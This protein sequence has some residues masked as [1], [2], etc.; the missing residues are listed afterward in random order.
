MLKVADLMTVE[1]ETVTPETSLLEVLERMK[2]TIC[3]QMP[4]LDED[5]QLVG[6]VTDRDLRLAMNSPLVLHERAQDLALLGAATVGSVMTTRPVT[7]T[8]DT[9]AAQAAKILSTY[10]FGALPVVDQDELVGIVSVSD[11]LDY[12]AEKLE[13]GGL[14]AGGDPAE[15]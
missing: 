15:E 12:L 8:P 2:A 5:G 10:K 6:I 7:V 13:G 4:V 3:R 1:P 14:A 11:F 9:P